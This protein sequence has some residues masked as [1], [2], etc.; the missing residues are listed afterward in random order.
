MLSP[1]ARQH[2]QLPMQKKKRNDKIDED[3]VSQDSFISVACRTK[4]VD[5]SNGALN[6]KLLDSRNGK[7]DVSAS[8]TTINRESRLNTRK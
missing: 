8:G 1:Q 7:A 3:Y 4:R 5:I 6:L 2:A